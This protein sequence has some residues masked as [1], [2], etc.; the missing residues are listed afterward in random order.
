[1]KVNFYF[2]EK[3]GKVGAECSACGEVFFDSKGRK[4]NDCVPK[5]IDHAHRE[6]KSTGGVLTAKP[7]PGRVN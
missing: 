2:V 3:D 6:H 1:M 4:G 7:K 5:C